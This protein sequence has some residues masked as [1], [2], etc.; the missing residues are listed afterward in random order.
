MLQRALGLQDLSK[1][2]NKMKSSQNIIKQGGID[3]KVARD[4]NRNLN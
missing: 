2:I 3:E 4:K 1:A